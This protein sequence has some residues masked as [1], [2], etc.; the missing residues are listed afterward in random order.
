M[1]CIV[2]HQQ[3]Q[4]AVALNV[5]SETQTTA[6]PVMHNGAEMKRKIVMIRQIEA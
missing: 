3:A 1:S 6:A 5:N 2:Q 4:S